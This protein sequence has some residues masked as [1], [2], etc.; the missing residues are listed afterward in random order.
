VIL[1]LYSELLRLSPG[2]LHLLL[3]FSLK[4]RGYTGENPMTGHKGD[5][6]TRAVVQ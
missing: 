1:S 3:D 6:R 2:V 5:Q 4:K